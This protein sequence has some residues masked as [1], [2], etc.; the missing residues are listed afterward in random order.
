MALCRAVHTYTHTRHKHTCAHTLTHM[1]RH[2]KDTQ[3]H[4]S[5]VPGCCAVRECSAHQRGTASSCGKA[6]SLG[7]LAC[8]MAL[9][10]PGSHWLNPGTVPTRNAQTHADQCC[11]WSAA[12][13]PVGQSLLCPCPPRPKHFLWWG[14]S[15]WVKGTGRC[16]RCCSH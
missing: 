9:V 16:Q 4:L 10:W 13:S 5:V 11:A 7:W 15:G 3:T 12:L 14:Q 6:P 8:S 1:Y 2:I